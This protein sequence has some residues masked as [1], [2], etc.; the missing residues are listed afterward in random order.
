MTLLAAANDLLLVFLALEILSLA[1][2]VLAG[3]ARR[4][5]VAEYTAAA[6]Q[7]AADYAFGKIGAGD[8]LELIF[9]AFDDQRNRAALGVEPANDVLENFLLN[10]PRIRAVG[11]LLAERVERAD[12][13][14]IGH[15]ARAGFD[16][17]I[18]HVNRALILKEHAAAV[19]AH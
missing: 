8:Q 4:D 19:H 10:L 1:L 2:Y 5:D 16:G 17:P 18:V 7:C 9:T 15:A 14:K 12:P 13:G 6:R 11:G 3:F